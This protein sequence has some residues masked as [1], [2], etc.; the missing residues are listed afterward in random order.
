MTLDERMRRNAPEDQIEIG[1]IAERFT[2]GQTGELLKMFIEGIKEK[3]LQKADTDPRFSAERVTG[4]LIALNTLQEEL[5]QC[6]D[7]KNQLLDEKK[8]EQK[9]GGVEVAP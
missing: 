4:A 9:V 7:I 3:T 5:D 2:Y 6:V 8:E 1:L